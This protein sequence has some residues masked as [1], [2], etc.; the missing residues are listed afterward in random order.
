M[1]RRTSELEAALALLLRVEQQAGRLPLWQREFR[2]H[3]TRKWRF[4]FAWPEQ[5]VAV[6]V[7]GG[8]WSGGRHTRGQGF[9]DDCIK[10]GEATAAGWQVYRATA[11]LIDEGP[12]GRLMD[13][14]RRSLPASAVLARQHAR[15][16]C[17]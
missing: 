8:I 1:L 2:F 17:E 13:W 7:E 9:E 12:D 3:P 16:N 15:G 11:S 6:E 14:L 4:D 10:Y 5:M